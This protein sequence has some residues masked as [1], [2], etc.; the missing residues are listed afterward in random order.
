[1][2]DLP[3]PESQPM[4]RPL[5]CSAFAGLLGVLAACGGMEDGGDAQPADLVP[6]GERYGGTAVIGGIADLQS[7][8]GLVSSDYNSNNIQRHMVFMTTVAYDQDI[9]VVPYLAERWDTVRV[10]GDSLELTFHIRQDV[11][12]HDGT[13]TTADD[14]LFTY[15]RVIDPATAFPNISA[16]DLYSRH[17]ELVDANTFRVRLRPHADFLDI[18]VQTP[19]MPKHLLGDVPP[20]ELI[21]HGFR[22]QP[23][24]NGPFRFLRRTP[25]QEWVFESN[26]DFP[27]A[28]GGRP[29][30]DRIVY[31]FVPENTTLLTELL[32]GAIDVF[33]NPP[34]TMFD[35]IQSTPGVELRNWMFRQYEYIAWN[36]RLPQFRDA[37]VRRALT[38]AINRQEMLDALRQGYGEIGRASVPP[39]HWAYDASDPETLIPYDPEGARRLLAEAGWTPGPDGALRDAQGNPFRFSLITN[40]GNDTRRDITELVQAQLGQ[41]GITVEP[42]QIEF[43]TMISTLQGS[44]NAAGERVR[45]FEAVVG[46][47]VVYFRQDDTDILHCRRLNQPYQYVGY[48]NERVDQLIDTLGVILDREEARPLWREYQRL[49]VQEA[50]YTVVFYPERVAGVRTRLQGAVMDI[51]GET[52]SAR[53]WWLLPQERTAGG[54]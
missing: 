36:T 37:R 2:R 7:M 23:V 28:L 22:Y 6:E 24:G 43:T 13:P 32:T 1:M 54:N 47:W 30:V 35:Q 11:R 17:A 10:A 29:Y 31:R 18:W 45:D 19:I 41:L 25:G 16:F 14:V 40:A 5:S 39:S 33:L 49:L 34:P 26:P 21:Q 51:R 52:I 27:E 42:R 8:N 12:W 9:Q 4:K 44:L 3:N 38:M 15:Q 46:G 48:C 53:D 50:P 20:G